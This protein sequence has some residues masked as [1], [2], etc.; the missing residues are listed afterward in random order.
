MEVWRNAEAG[1]RHQG[2]EKMEE[3]KKWQMAEEG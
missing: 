1:F 2:E 3:Q